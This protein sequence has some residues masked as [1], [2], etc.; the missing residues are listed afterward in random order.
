VVHSFSGDGGLN[1][2]FWGNGF[3]ISENLR[4]GIDASY[5]FGQSSRLSM[6]F[7]PDSSNI[8]G[9]KVENHISVGDFIFDYGIQYDLKLGEKT[10]LTIG[11]TYA[12]K[13]NLS[14]NY[15][16]LSKTIIGGYNGLL[17]QVVDTIEYRPDE[18]GSIVLPA[19]LGFG[20]A[21]TNEGNWMIGADFEWQKWKEF[22]AFGVEDSLSN[23]WRVT[24]GGAFTP[25]HTN[26]SSIFKRMTYRAG[27][28][29]NQSY[30]KFYNN[31]ITEFGISFGV[32]FPLKNSKTG[33]DLGVD[34]GRRGTTDNNLIQENFFDISLG[35]SIQEN[36]FQKRKY[37]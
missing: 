15:N 23:S 22:E 13:F 19:R 10:K 37:R 32:S 6:I 14:A 9:T 36:W 17:E 8:F 1:R 12:Q 24:L 25:K 2:V 29:Y 27:L 33:I 26:I 4:V 16:Y 18:E 31:P 21:L 35:V 11:A 34:F 30:L 5:L 7:Y 3:N 28:R 20:L